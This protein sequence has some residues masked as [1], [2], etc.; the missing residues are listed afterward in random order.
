MKNRVDALNVTASEAATGRRPLLPGGA[1][2]TDFGAARDENEIANDDEP[3]TFAGRTRRDVPEISEFQE[4]K[5]GAAPI[6]LRGGLRA[7]IR[8]TVSPDYRALVAEYFR[9]LQ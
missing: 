4:P 5:P 2:R 1:I 6:R 8:A 7:A 3:E 9:R